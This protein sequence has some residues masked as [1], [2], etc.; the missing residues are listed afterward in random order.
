[1]RLLDS[2]KFTISF[3]VFISSIH[4]FYQIL[5]HFIIM[6]TNLHFSLILFQEYFL[7]LNAAI[8]QILN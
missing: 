2:D 7:L 3:P 6:S 8:D 1:M 5:M 4:N